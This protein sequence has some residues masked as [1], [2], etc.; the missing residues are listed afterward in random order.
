MAKMTVNGL[1][2]I[3]SQRTPRNTN[4]E[5][6]SC[7]WCLNHIIQN[8]IVPSHKRS[9]SSPAHGFQW[10][11]IQKSSTNQKQNRLFVLQ[12]DFIRI[13]LLLYTYT[14][15]LFIHK[16][17]VH[18]VFCILFHQF[19]FF[20]QKFIVAR[21]VEYIQVSTLDFSHYEYKNYIY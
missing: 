6:V 16:P 3:E 8:F 15:I 21:S 14:L 10:N 13:G 19:Q 2:A 12:F 7:E 5:D 18:H 20:M 9:R 17:Y 4:Y 1:S 11:W